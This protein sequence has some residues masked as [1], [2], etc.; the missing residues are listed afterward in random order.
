MVHQE[1][2]MPSGHQDIHILKCY[3]I[4]PLCA[5]FSRGNINM[6]L[7]FIS[8]L[9]TDMIQIMEILPDG[10]QQPILHSQYSGDP[11]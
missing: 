7:Q 1:L 5:K 3:L 9:Y 4:N 8:F 2:P 11:L 10:S 6:Y